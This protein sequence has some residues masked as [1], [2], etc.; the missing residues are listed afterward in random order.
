MAAAAT[1][2]APRCRPRR[3]ERGETTDLQFLTHARPSMFGIDT[4]IYSIYDPNV[5]NYIPYM[6][7][8]GWN[9]N[10]PKLE[11]ELRNSPLRTVILVYRSGLGRRKPSLRLRSAWDATHP[12]RLYGRWGCPPRRTHLHRFQ[13]VRTSETN[14]RTP[15]DGVDHRKGTPR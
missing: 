8:L 5:G 1:R 13:R 2:E 11:G 7:G 9:F 10:E 12:V 6:D 14:D 3:D 15:G 4:Y